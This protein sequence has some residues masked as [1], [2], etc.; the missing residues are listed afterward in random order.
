MITRFNLLLIVSLFFCSMVDA[1]II[2]EDSVYDL[3]TI[4]ERRGEVSRKLYFTN[5]GDVPVVIDAV[6]S[7]CGCVGS[8]ADRKPIKPAGRSYI[9][10]SF[11]PKYMDGYFS[12]Y[13]RVVYNGGK[14]VVRL[15]IHGS[16]IPKV[17]PITDEYPF[18][19]DN[20][21]YFR[22]DM[23]FFGY[24]K[25]GENKILALDIVND[26]DKEVNIDFKNIDNNNI[27]IVSETN[28]QPKQRGE[29]VFSYT[30][31]PIDDEILFEI[32]PSFNGIVSSKALRVRVM[33][34]FYTEPYRAPYLY[35]SLY[36]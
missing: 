22:Q 28:F 15:K 5:E 31:P 17:R 11:D 19:Y 12:K 27:K 1:Q 8:V 16:V 33:K 26:S 35:K 20:E 3:G 29:L 30:R 23:L 4:E 25:I 32:R 34:V 10:V 18:C 21:I 24:M 14:D 7:N 13:I 9:N 36:K 2:F 6:Y